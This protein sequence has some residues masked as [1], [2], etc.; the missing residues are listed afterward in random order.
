MLAELP[1][2]SGLRSYGGLLYVPYEDD[3]AICEVMKQ[4]AG[5]EAKYGW[6]KEANKQRA[7]V[8]SSWANTTKRYVEY[9]KS[10]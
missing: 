2:K 9:V 4:L 6:Q 5:N 10:L 8:T 7:Q 1:V 3:K